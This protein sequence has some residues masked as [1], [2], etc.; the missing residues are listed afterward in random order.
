[1]FWSLLIPCA[2][3]VLVDTLVLLCV[4]D[5]KRRL[6]PQLLC[7]VITNPLLHLW[8]PLVYMAVTALCGG[9]N[10]VWNSV[11]VGCL[12]IGIVFAEAGIAGIYIKENY[13]KRLLYSAIVNASSFVLGLIFANPLDKLIRILT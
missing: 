3:T 10:A 12:E 13:K 1:M 5:G 9:E 8:L 2:F 4:K 7:N 11:A 6:K